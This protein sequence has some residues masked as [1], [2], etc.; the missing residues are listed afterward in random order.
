VNKRCISTPMFRKDGKAAR[1]IEGRKLYACLE[2]VAEEHHSLLDLSTVDY[3]GRMKA[4]SDFLLRIVSR[5]R[6]ATVFMRSG[7]NIFGKL[8][9]ACSAF[10]K[11]DPELL[12]IV[13]DAT[14]IESRKAYIRAMRTLESTSTIGRLR[15][16]VLVAEAE[17]GAAE[18]ITSN[19]E[20]LIRLNKNLECLNR[21][22]GAQLN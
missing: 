12:K 2:P 9:T 5:A 16:S 11:D 20:T 14:S 17:L 1:I 6:H 8:N 21:T 13:E 7:N 19:K 4:Y 3:L 15:Y 18:E 22:R 10:G